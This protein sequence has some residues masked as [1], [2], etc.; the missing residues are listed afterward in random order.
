MEEHP[1][2]KTKQIKQMLQTV[3]QKL[4][5]TYSL[6]WKLCSHQ[7]LLV[8]GDG[9]YNGTIKTRK[10]VQATGGESSELMEIGRSEELRELFEFLSAGEECGE[11]R[12]PG[13]ALLPEDLTECEWFYLLCM[14]FTFSPGCGLPGKAFETQNHVW[15]TRANDTTS[16]LFSRS[17]LAKSAGIQTVVCIPL[18]NG[19]L[20][21][22]TEEM[23]K[24][25]IHLTQK[26]RD[27]F[28]DIHIN[29]PSP[30][31][32]EHS[33][34][35]PALEFETSPLIHG[36]DGLCQETEEEIYNE[37]EDWNNGNSTESEIKK[38]FSKSEL[39]IGRN[40]SEQ[41]NFPRMVEIESMELGFANNGAGDL[42]RSQIE[43]LEVDQR[44]RRV[45]SFDQDDKELYLAWNFLHD[46]PCN[47]LQC[48]SE[49]RTSQRM[50]KDILSV[51]PNIHDKTYVNSAH[52]RGKKSGS[53]KGILQDETNGNHVVAERRR[54]EKLNKRFMVLR[55]LVPCVTK[56]DKASILADTIEHVRQLRQHIHDLESQNK[57]TSNLLAV[58]VSDSHNQINSPEKATKVWGDSSLGIQVSITESNA[59]IRLQCHYKDGILLKI[60]QKLDELN[61]ETTFVNSTMANG[62]FMAEF[63]TKV[64]E[65]CGM[66]ASIREIKW[67]IHQ[68]LSH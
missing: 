41:T 19:V 57:K 68:L 55:A 53:W 28:V 50:L 29:S 56:L 2:P 35:S 26:A 36:M 40:V 18:T 20:E 42:E 66:R 22:G 17:I 9:C 43:V 23:V 6:F 52:M 21:L 62:K 64:K 30:A 61:L 5:W 3:V 33:T 14:S 25:D 38:A 24:E 51:L 8:W 34:S 45:H 59:V 67:A 39:E 31:L 37:N 7:G 15:L 4:G 44:Y 10:T 16:Q 60:M 47:D 48:S 1:L 63:K 65:P 13:L 11:R 54:R 32:S 12:R 27:I 46:G 49:T 58:K